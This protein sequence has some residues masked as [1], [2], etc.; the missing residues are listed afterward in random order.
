MTRRTTCSSPA[1]RCARCWPKGRNCPR[2]S[3]GRK[4]RKSS[5]PFTAPRTGSDRAAARRA[6]AFPPEDAAVQFDIAHG[7]RPPWE[8]P[9]SQTAGPGGLPHQRAG[10]AFPSTGRVGF[11][12]PRRTRKSSIIDKRSPFE[13]NVA[14]S[15]PHTG[16]ETLQRPGLTDRRDPRGSPQAR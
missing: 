7:S 3:P 15:T 8:P 1:P 14:A 5:P 4:W 13:F 10:W 6:R 2:N 11:H 9:L 12:D 16:T